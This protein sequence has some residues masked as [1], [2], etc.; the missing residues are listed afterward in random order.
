MPVEKLVPVPERNAVQRLATFIHEA[1][2]DC[3]AF[4]TDLD[5][6]AAAW[7]VTAH[8]TPAA[9]KAHKSAIIYFTTHENGSAKSLEGRIPM[10]EPFASFVKAFVRRKQDGRRLSLGPLASVANAARYLHDE[11]A[12][13]GH[14]PASL[15]AG[16]FDDAAREIQRRT[17]G[18]TAYRLGNGLQEIAAVV[19]RHG[20]SKAPLDWTSPI[21]KAGDRRS[22]TTPAALASAEAKMPSTWALDELARISHLVR[23]PSDVILMGCIKLLHCAPWRIG[24]VLLMPED[25][26][27]EEQKTGPEGP[28]HDE[29]GRPV[30]RYGLRYWKEKS[31]DADVKWIPTVMVD[32]A[33]AAVADIRRHTEDARELAAWMEQHPGRARLP[34]PDL[35]P[36]QT[37][38]TAQVADMFGMFGYVAGAQWLRRHELGAIVGHR[39]LATREEI[40]TG[41]L[42]DAARLSEDDHRG[43]P[44]SRHL[45]LTFRYAHHEAK[46][47]N[48][49]VVAL[50]TDQHVADFL[51]GRQSERGRTKSIFE[52]FERQ[53]KDGSSIEMNS[54]MFRHWLNTL[55]QAGGLDQALV[56]RWS[57]RD[58]AGQN[59]DYDHVGGV[60]LARSFRGMMEDGRVVGALADLHDAKPPVD[61]AAF[62][63]VVLATAH[64]TEIGMCDLD[65]ITSTC[66][67]FGACQ[68]CESCIVRKGDP[69]ARTRTE[70]LRDE[71]AWLLER[72]IAEVDDGT[73][74]ASNHAHSQVETLKALDRILA[75]HDDPAI[76]DGTLVQP[77][78]TSPD[79]FA[80][81]PLPVAP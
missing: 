81:P 10:A 78:A 27:V 18:S 73:I 15:T 30:M 14:D 38:T 46:A 6:D 19:D 40:E 13:F 61:R 69:A 74:G 16:T 80:G 67:E 43:L 35:G 1:R 57:G 68:T 37:Y 23:D 49:C 42:R 31:E 52:K 22:R 36:D 70:D 51:G 63:D 21:R 41:L 12:P 34:G 3:A 47:T 75:I 26:E 32:T 72:T 17:A 62:R 53:M 45:F 9:S 77:N 2:H 5:W 44:L 66:P 60:E 39:H 79:H 55:A 56:A 20:L 76:P 71:T 4:G 54:H 25:C 7:D 24:E 33:R 64:V 28:V 50:T 29:L 48:P 11:L 65:W 59:A 8:C 58:D